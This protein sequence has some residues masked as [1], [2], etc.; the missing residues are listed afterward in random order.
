MELYNV[1]VGGTLGGPQQ[2]LIDTMLSLF[3]RK[4]KKSN[5]PSEW[6]NRATW[7]YTRTQINQNEENCSFSFIKCTSNAKF[8]LDLKKKRKKKDIPTYTNIFFLKIMFELYL[9]L[10]KSFK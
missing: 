2:N 9:N 6:S 10:I 4:K 3:R 5:K 1:G 8:S 7:K